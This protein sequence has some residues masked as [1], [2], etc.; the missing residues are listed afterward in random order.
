M[1]TTLPDLLVDGYPQYRS[2]ST[3][4]GAT[5]KY[6]GE[7]SVITAGA[8]ATGDI[9]TDTKPVTGT[10]VYQLGRSDWSELIV[11]TEVQTG[12]TTAISTTLQETRYQCTW[13]PNDIPLEQHPAFGPNGGSDLFATASG[14]PTRKH[15][16][17]V[18]GWENEQDPHLKSAFQY[19]PLKSDGSLGAT[20]TLAGAA[21]TYAKLRMLGFSTVPAFLPV[22]SKVGTYNGTSAPGVGSIGQYTA[23]PDGS[24]YPEVSTGVGYQWIKIQDDAERIGRNTRWDRSERWKGYVK[25]Y[26]DIDTINP[27]ANTLPT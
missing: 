20:I 2:S 25:V 17:D 11:E 3:S 27:A 19:K 24:G 26:L 9:W 12:I 6:R 21:I 1:P 14:S 18:Y 5:Y 4:S 22:W 13:E 16:A 23:T 15:I 10:D 8:P 7:T